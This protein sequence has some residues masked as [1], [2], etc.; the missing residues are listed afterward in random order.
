MYTAL[1]MCRPRPC[2]QIVSVAL[3]TSTLMS[4]WP[5]KRACAGSMVICSATSLGTTVRGSGPVG[6]LASAACAG[7]D[8]SRPVAAS[9]A[10][11]SRLG[12]RV[13]TDLS[14]VQPTSLPRAASRR[15]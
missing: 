2:I 3:A 6:M 7:L 13:I 12:R 1:L 14:R 10:V 5:E 9:R 15:P 4:T 8:C 11:A